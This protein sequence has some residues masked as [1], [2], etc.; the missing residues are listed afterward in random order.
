M[1]NSIPPILLDGENIDHVTHTKF[2]GVS[3]D[4][5][6]NWKHHIDNIY[7]KLS[8]TTGVLYR[9]RHN[10]LADEAMLSIYY[11][12]FYPHL[13]YC[14]SVWGCTWHSFLD[15]LTIAQKKIFH[16]TQFL[17]KFDSTTHISEV[18]NILRFPFLHKY[19]TLLLIF[20][21]LA[22]NT[23][24]KLVNNVTYTRSN[25]INLV[26]PAFRTILFKNSIF[27]FAPQL[28]NSMPVDIKVLLNSSTFHSY[29][30]EI[31]NT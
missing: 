26:C 11:T 4:E 24:F 20:K 16:C 12:L 28:F 23:Y 21:S 17:K 3:I 25:N 31:K 6:L 8:K 14:V 27:S 5:N 1:K 9:V 13:I 15:K 22:L 10:L 2:L 30:R 18:N 7:I 19:F 29:K